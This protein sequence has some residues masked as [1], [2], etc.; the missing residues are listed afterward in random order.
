MLLIFNLPHLF[1]FGLTDRANLEMMSKWERVTGKGQALN[2]QAFIRESDMAAD[3]SRA[4]AINPSLQRAWIGLGRAYWLVGR[5]DEAGHSWDIA[6]Q[7]DKTDQVAMFLRATGAQLSGDSHRWAQLLGSELAA[8]GAYNV[9]LRADK[10][11]NRETAIAWY[12]ISITQSPNRINV[13][14]LS[15]LYTLNGSTND[16]I[17]IWTQLVVATDEMDEDHWWAMGHVA[18]LRQEWPEALSAYGHGATLATDP[19]SYVVRAGWAA[20]NQR[21]GS[22]AQRWFNQAREARRELAEPLLGLGNAAQLQN[23]PDQAIV[24]FLRAQAVDSESIAPLFNLGLVYFQQANYP[25]AQSYFKKVLSLSSEH[26]VSYYYLAMC[27]M[28]LDRP[29]E[30]INLLEESIILASKNQQSDKP[31]VWQMLIGDWQARS[32]QRDNAL[33][34]YEQALIWHPNELEIVKRIQALR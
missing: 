29:E 1:A 4:I 9:G 18:E 3:Y 25:Q 15:Q 17:G 13:E 22:E 19:Y 7:L 32:G 5:C 10:S 34:S 14:R 28:A 23:D 30:A 21:N 12:L 2:C 27:S 20:I 6:L 11:G 31:W 16:A 33:R 26:A 24:W 8:Q